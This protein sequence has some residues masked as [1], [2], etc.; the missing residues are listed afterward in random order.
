MWDGSV[1]IINT[2]TLKVQSTFSSGSG[3]S[4]ACALA[5]SANSELF[6][7]NCYANTVTVHS[8]TGALLNTI[9]GFSYPDSLAIVAGLN[10]LVVSN[11]ASSNV[12][13]ID[14]NSYA[15][16]SNVP[17]APNGSVIAVAPD[18]MNVYTAGWSG[19]V[20]NLN[21]CT[22]ATGFSIPWATG[23]PVAMVVH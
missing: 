3:A 11:G 10:R 8:S 17:V 6:V 16:I 22:N 20:T 18:G 19:T 2:S 15:V 14:L 23:A 1:S 13:V 5:V 7:A 12:T 21:A 9:S 4:G